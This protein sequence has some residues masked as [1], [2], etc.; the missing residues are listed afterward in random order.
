MPL[1][2]WDLS[3][4]NV[5]NPRTLHIWQYLQTWSRL[6]G[7]RGRAGSVERQKL[8]E[9]FAEEDLHQVSTVTSVSSTCYSPH[10][11][12]VWIRTIDI[13]VGT[14]IMGRTMVSLRL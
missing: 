3:S 5:A 14:T 11:S 12:S 1:M 10:T 9:N 6:C 8:V 4:I 13:L 2:F 7:M